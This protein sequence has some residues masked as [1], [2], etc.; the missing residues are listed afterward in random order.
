MRRF[1][2]SIFEVVSVMLSVSMYMY[3]ESP[4][5]FKTSVQLSRYLNIATSAFTDLLLA[6]LPVYFLWDVQISFRNKLSICCLTGLG[7]L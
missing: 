4:E 7:M 6:L 3:S 2:L 1:V 5:P